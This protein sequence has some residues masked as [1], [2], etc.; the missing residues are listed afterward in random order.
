MALKRARTDEH[1][2]QGD[3]QVQVSSLGYP[4]AALITAPALSTDFAEATTIPQDFSRG[5]RL[6]IRLRDSIEVPFAGHKLRLYRPPYPFTQATVLDDGSID[7]VQVTDNVSVSPGFIAAVSSAVSKGYDRLTVTETGFVLHP[8]AL[9]VVEGTGCRITL[10]K[11]KEMI[12]EVILQYMPPILMIMNRL[13]SVCAVTNVPTLSSIV[14]EC[15]KIIRTGPYSVPVSNS[16]IA[17]ATML[18]GPLDLMKGANLTTAAVGYPPSVGPLARMIAVVAH[19]RASQED[20][21]AFYRA[22]ASVDP[23]IS[24]ALAMSLKL[25]LPMVAKEPS[26]FFEGSPNV[27]PLVVKRV[28]D[29]VATDFVL[30]SKKEVGAGAVHNYFSNPDAMKVYCLSKVNPILSQ[31]SNEARAGTAYRA[32][33]LGAQ[34]LVVAAAVNYLPLNAIRVAP[35][36]L[37]RPKAVPTG[38]VVTFAPDL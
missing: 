11:T 34:N 29:L 22:Q 12:P 20:K 33:D 18:D 2:V 16:L 32:V 25:T 31:R 35:T 4:F 28:S 26:V 21:M 5:M 9:V 7:L 17:I 1:G 38:A 36:P 24:H 15:I 27:V 3:E 13:T 10:Y 30:L 6:L 23:S 8:R 14:I 19:G 37:T